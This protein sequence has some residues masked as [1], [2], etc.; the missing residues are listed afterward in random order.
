[1]SY[2]FL[3]KYGQVEKGTFV[4]ERYLHVLH[5]IIK[6]EAGIAVAD[7]HSLHLA[8]ESGTDM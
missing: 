5:G 1:M 4:R 7:P 2:V 3:R 6:A 8:R